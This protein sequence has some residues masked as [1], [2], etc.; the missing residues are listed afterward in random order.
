M[1]LVHH[2]V[3]CWRH[4]CWSQQV[5]GRA[6]PLTD[7]EIAALSVDL[8]AV[9]G[10]DK[11]AI[12]EQLAALNDKS[13][14]PTFVLAMRWT[15]SNIHVAKALSALTGEKI[16]TW[17]QAYHWQQRHPEVIPHLTYRDVKLRFLGNTDNDFLPLFQPPY[18]ERARMRIRLE[19]IVWGGALFDNIPSLDAATM[20]TADEASYLLDTDLVFG[21]SINGDARAY[22]LRIMGWH[23]MVNDVIGGV[24]VALAYCTLCGAGILF[25][26]SA[27]DQT[28]VF[29]SSG[30]LYRSNKLMFDRQ[31]NSLWNQFA[32]EPVVGPLADSGVKLSVLPLTTTTWSEWR[33]RYP[34]TRVLS[35][36]TGHIRNYDSGFVYREYF[37][38]PDLMFPAAVGNTTGLQQKDIV[39]GV[40][41]FAASKAWPLTVFEHTRVL[42]DKVGRNPVVLIGDA[43]TKT[44][45]AYERAA[46]ERFSL[47]DSGQLVS[48]GIEWHADE[49]FL[50]SASDTERRARLPGHIAYWFAWENFMGFDSELYQP[51][52]P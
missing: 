20:L 26:T 1:S 17:H 32:G 38:S 48:D 3:V 28:F 18:D 15:G 2:T 21:V 37:A 10:D 23:E 16:E 7:A 9:Q 14:I 33:R 43:G 40:R 42:N 25:D 31:T 46:D 45:R 4:Y 22:P 29:G 8:F 50:R 24:P 13:L 49:A 51:S 30:L 36:N 41:A 19:E 11:I 27:G 34:D 47:N 12:V 44:V 52:K 6:L 39:F 5:Y 35:L